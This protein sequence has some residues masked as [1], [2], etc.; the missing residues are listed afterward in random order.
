MNLHATVEADEIEMQ[1]AGFVAEHDEPK[2]IAS[3]YAT[4]QAT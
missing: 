2:A 3:S 1:I 4:R